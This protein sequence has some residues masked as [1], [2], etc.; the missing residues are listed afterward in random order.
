MLQDRT[1][2]PHQAKNNIQVVTRVPNG[3]EGLSNGDMAI[4][5]S[6]MG[7]MGI[8]VSRMGVSGVT[9]ISVCHRY[10]SS[11]ARLAEIDSYSGP[12]VGSA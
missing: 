4:R 9:P 5:V 8:R 11:V 7:D 1:Q 2:A 10:I 12:G 6:R 3:D